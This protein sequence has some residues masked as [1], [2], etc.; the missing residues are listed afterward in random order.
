MMPIANPRVCIIGAGLAGLTTGKNLQD[1]GIDFTILEATSNFGGTWRYEPRVGF[2]ENGLPVF[3]SMYK[4]LRT[5]LPKPTMELKGF[6][7]PSNIPSFPTWDVYYDYIRKYVQHFQ[8]EKHIK[9]QHYVIKVSRINNVWRVKHKYLPTGEEM[10]DEFDFVIVGTGH[11]NKPNRPV[12][13]GE[14]F[15][16]GNI[17]HSHDYREPEPYRN[18][19]VLTVGAGPSGLD[20]TMDVATVAKTIFHSHHSPQ[21]FKTKFPPNYVKKPD[22]KEYNETGV[23]FVD[24][25]YE[26]IDDVIY[27]TGYLFNFSFLDESAGLN[28]SSKTVTPLHKFMVNI[29]EPSLIIIG[30]IEKA[31]LAIALEAQAR[32]TA[33]LVKGKFSLPSKEDM[34][35]EW[36]RRADLC[37]A[38]GRTFSNLH[39]LAE[40]ED[41]YYEEL[42]KESGIERVP[43]VM[44][45]IRNTDAEAKIENLY[46]YRNYVY[47]VIDKNTFVRRLENETNSVS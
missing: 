18:K 42:S 3:T 40:G 21:N 12:M 33:A 19:R 26:D 11:F 6:P 43:P 35:K 13:K 34:M 10:E 27:C 23:T 24:G 46:T 28:V 38:R 32:Y 16:K 47:E 9:F 22:I 20:I 44:F 29:N 25:S 39:F 15:F 17:I 36:Q 41:D 30:L 37:I 45:K 8:I 31:C 7:I 5:N 14:E 2:Y 4:H 1:E